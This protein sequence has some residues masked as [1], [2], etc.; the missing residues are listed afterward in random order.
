M[1]SVTDF[2]KRL[3]EFILVT[4]MIIAVITLS[5]YYLFPAPPEPTESLTD[6]EKEA[7][8]FIIT[9]YSALNRKSFDEL[10]EFFLEDAILLSPEGKTYFG[11]EKIETYYENLW[12]NM[13]EYGVKQNIL[14]IEVDG[15]YAK[16][17]FCSLS[18]ERTTGETVPHFRSFRNDFILIREE[19]NW[20]IA[21]ITMEKKSCW[22]EP[23][24]Y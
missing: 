8:Q 2:K 22:D 7:Y 9:Y 13:V 12:I 20:K 14:S 15:D 16:A 10:N 24:L 5:F 3:P 21:G 17:T 4:I 6:E 18:I 19:G 1:S 11:V 23:V